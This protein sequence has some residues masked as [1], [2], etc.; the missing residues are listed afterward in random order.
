LLLRKI[1]LN[2]FKVF[3]AVLQHRGVAAAARELGV[4]PSAVSHALARLRQALGDELFVSGDAGMVPTERAL[5][6]APGIREGLGHFSGAVEA[7]PFDPATSLR[8]FRIA[9]TDYASVVMLPRLVAHMVAAAPQATLRVFPFSRLDVVRHLDEGRLDLA[10]GWFGQLPDRM[11]RRAIIEEGEAIVVRPGHPLTEGKVTKERLVAFPHIVVELTGTE[12]MAVDGFLDD[13]GVARRVWI[14]RLLIDI[15]D[16][17]EGLVGRV[18]VSV[19]TYAAVPPML[20]ATDMVA[21]LPHRL[22]LRAAKHEGLVLLDLPYEPLSVSVEAV[23]HQ[24]AERDA[25][26]QWLTDALAA[27]T[28]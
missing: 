2:L 11:G 18:A 26:R 5:A 27:T 10:L 17:E 21:T 8:T 12:E 20:L 9:A 14:E 23:W 25:G 1:D 24:R 22:A 15:A 3:D 6:L 13:R 16:G 7:Q 4:T 19:P 28:D